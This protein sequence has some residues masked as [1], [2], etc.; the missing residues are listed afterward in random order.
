MMRD[1]LIGKRV[2]VLMGGISAEREI[3]LRTGKGVFTALKRKGYDAVALDWK[4]EGEI[5]SL[6]REAGVAVVWNA[7]HGTGGEDGFIQ[8]RLESMKIPYTGSGVRASELAMDKV[9]S[10]ELFRAEGI[11]TPDWK[12]VARGAAKEAKDPG[13]G[14]P[15]VVK[16][17]CEGSTVGVTILGGP[18]GLAEAL[19]EA[20]SHHGDVILERYVP[21]REISV[22]ILD[23]AAL[24]SV[25][26]RPKSGF[27][28]Y[29]AKY[30]S[31]D[32]TYLVPAPLDAPVRDSVHSLAARSH[33]ALGCAGYSRVDLRVTEAGEPWVLEVNTLPGLT[34]TSL[35]PKIA[36]HAG[37][38]YDT[39]VER[40]LDSAWRRKAAPA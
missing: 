26:I 15:L 5:E 31:G 33:A 1:E 25:E 4:V 37:I 24:G 35:Y 36:D 14:Y 16:P 21:G 2:G 6:L 18:G 17:S 38:D 39:V 40:I 29:R 28:D 8:R 3:S 19:E 10:K 20:A 23:G 12:V 9:R 11:P 27:Y 32:T 13:L 30:L 34:E 7:L 22:A